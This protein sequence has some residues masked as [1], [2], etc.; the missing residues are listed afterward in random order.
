[1]TRRGMLHTSAGLAVAAPVAP[2]AGFV[3]GCGEDE[4]ASSST[5]TASGAPAPRDGDEAL[6]RLLA[7]NRRFRDEMALSP[8]RDTVRR[9]ELAEGQEP[10]A[11]ILGCADSRVPPEVIFDEGLGSLF[12]V[13]IAGN[14]AV[15]PFVV[16]SVEYAVEHLGSVLVMV[17][18]HE[19]C[20][21]VKGAIAEADGAS[22]PGSIGDV[23]API[24][25]V[26]EGVSEDTP[27]LSAEELVEPS[28]Q[29][30]VTAAVEDLS[31]ADGLI[32]ELVDSGE[33]KLVGAEYMLESGEVALL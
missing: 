18:G 17:L 1:M 3:A 5:T 31:T 9:L 22:E 12:V 10:F 14:T 29:A 15:D 24:V 25:P 11:V 19:G 6:E 32:A 28:V 13:R 16:G 8:E 2:L 4:P 23:I 33:L 27:E 21:A 30:N 7:G 20:G 26:V